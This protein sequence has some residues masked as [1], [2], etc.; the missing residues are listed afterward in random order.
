MSKV[1][2]ILDI[3]QRFGKGEILTKK[4][5]AEAYEINEKSVQRYIAD[6]NR[7]MEISGGGFIRYNTRK[8][9]YEMVGRQPVG[10]TDADIFA[11]LKILFEVRAF[12][13]TEMQHLYEALT[14]L[15]STA[16]VA[17]SIRRLTENEM[18]HYVPPRQSMEI[19]RLLWTINNTIIDNVV[20]RISYMRTS[21][22]EIEQDVQPKG[23]LFSGSHFYLVANIC[24]V[25]K[26]EET[27][28]LIDR[29]TDY[30]P[31]RRKFMVPDKDR[32]Q[33]GEKR[34]RIP[35]M[36]YGELITL[37]FRYWGRS[38]ETVLDKLPTATYLQEPDGKYMIKAEVCSGG[39]VMW[40]LSQRE[41]IEVIRPETLRKE[42]RDT[43]E[44][45]RQNYISPP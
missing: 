37:W 41:F 12:P 7:F 15:C 3:Y 16:E 33:A 27:I 10:L 1:V 32:F 23:I 14:N 29:I 28:F 13:E 19:I 21:G 43:I 22:H 45:M 4:Q 24:G 34:K 6:I 17:D 2:R 31:T 39:I 25:E 5:L 38:L 26:H 9:A 44:K 30:M 40:L 8:K 36:Y 11:L 20:S 18:A 35:F 42:M